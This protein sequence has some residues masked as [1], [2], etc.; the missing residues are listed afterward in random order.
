MKVKILESSFGLEAGKTYRAK[1]RK[2]GYM[3]KHRG[4]EKFVSSKQAKRAK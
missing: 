2:L 4:L 3:V 1:K